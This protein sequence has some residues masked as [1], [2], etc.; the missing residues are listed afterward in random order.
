MSVAVIIVNYGTAALAI[1]AVESVLDKTHDG[2]EIEIHLVDNASPGDDAEQFRQL[3]AS[4]DGWEGKVTLWLEDENHGFGRANNLVMQAIVQPNET[5]PAP[6]YVLLLNPDARLENEAIAHL[7]TRLDE[8]PDVGAV[9][10]AVSMPDGTNVT[11]AFRFPG[12][13]HEIANVMN[14]GPVSRVLKNRLAPLPVDTPAGPVDWVTGAAVMFRLKA[15]QQV[16]FFDPA[17]FLY[18]EEVDLMHRLSDAG[19]AIHYQPEARVIH[20]EGAATNVESSAAD[21]RRRPAYVY[22]SWRRYFSKTYGGR[23]ALLI[24]L[25]VFIAAALGRVISGLRRQQTRLPLRFFRDQWRYVIAPLAE[26]RGDAEY[27]RDTARYTRTSNRGLINAN[28]P[29]IGFWALVAEDLRTYDYDILAQGFWA[30]F[31]HRFG[32]WRMSLRF[33]LIRMP[34]SVV[35]KVMYKVTQWVCGIDLPYSVV[36]GRRVKLEHFGGMVLVAE[37]IGNDVIIRQNTTFGIADLRNITAR[38]SI[39]D[40]V[41]IGVGAVLIGGITIGENAVIGANAVVVKDVPA[42]SV[43]VGIPAQILRRSTPPKNLRSHG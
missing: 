22:R 20:H 41:E 37:R 12:A 29:G 42:N 15:L 10:A 16:D 14:F 1:E 31:W 2:R 36:V 28:P 9:G 7:A 40:G 25:G 38:P 35:Y 21:R 24:A 6:D 27:D 26:L 23:R 17:F 5:R 33:Q 8:H 19:W 11:A 30:L 34:F 39:G 32:N 13:G 18:F 4:K 3:A 43:A